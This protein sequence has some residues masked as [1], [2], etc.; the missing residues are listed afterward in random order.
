MHNQN[1][2]IFHDASGRRWSR[3]KSF[4]FI[5]SIIFSLLT[6]IFIKSLFV[7][8]VFNIPVQIKE[9]KTKLKAMDQNA[10]NHYLS[11][12]EW[13]QFSRTLNKNQN[14]LIHEQKNSDFIN[15]GFYINWD[16]RS[17]KSLEENAKFLTHVASD[18]FTI[19][20][21]DSRLKINND[22]ELLH[23][24]KEKKVNFMPVL[25]NLE[26]DKWMP[27]AVEDIVNND[28]TVKEQFIKK[29]T[30]EIN[31]INAAGLIVDF[32]M[33][34][35]SYRNNY[36][37]FFELLSHQ[38]KE[39]QKQ[40]WL[41]LPMGLELRAYNLEG[42]SVF[43]DKFIASL[44]DENSEND[45]PG[46]ISSISWV[47]GWSDTI[48]AYGSPEQWI[49]DI[50][51]YGY[52]WEKNKKGGLIS[53]PDAMIRARQSGITNFAMN[54]ESLEPNFIYEIN[55]NIHEVWFLDA[56]TFLNTFNAVK[57]KMKGGVS[58]STLGF[59]DAAVWKIF[60]NFL[61]EE[62]YTD[63]ELFNQIANIQTND[64]IA[65]VGEG[66]L[67]SFDNKAFDGKR[68][69][70]QNTDGSFYETYT[71]I[72]SYY[73]VSRQRTDSSKIAI[74]FDDGPDP[75]YT[76]KLL[77][78]LKENNVQATFF[79]L[80]AKAEKQ[81]EL[82][83]RI[84]NEGHL[85]GI[86]SYTH[87]D[88]Y[89]ISRERITLELNASERLIQAITGKSALLFRPP[90]S[91]NKPISY[92]EFN[93][94][95]QIQDMGY[96]TIAYTI[97][98]KDWEKPGVEKILENI[99]NERNEGNVVLLHDAGGDRSQT[100]EALPLII[101]FFRDRG[102]KIVSLDEVAG[103][104]KSVLMPFADAGKQNLTRIVAGTGIKVKRWLNEIFWAFIIISTVLVV[105]RGAIVFFF[106]LRYKTKK[107]QS[108]DNLF[109]PQVTILISAYNEG[110]VIEKTLLSLIN[111]DYKGK[112]EIIIIDD[113]SKDDTSIVVSSLAKKFPEIIL[114]RQENAGKA[115]ALK[116][117]ISIAKNEIIIM[118]DADTQFQ[119]DT[120]R[121]LVIPFI[122]PKVGA[123]SGHA[124][125]GNSR[126]FI[127]RC[128]DLEYIS[129]FNLDRRAYHELN[130]I[131]VVPGA[132]CAV[133]K[134]ALLKAGGITN[135]TL[136]EDTDFT[137]SLH[138]TGYRVVY[139]K[140][141][142]AWTEAPETIKSL[143]K[144]RIRWGYGT[145]QCLWK[146]RDMA[147]SPGFGTLGL[148]AIPGMW[149]FHI[150]LIAIGPVIDTFFLLTLLNPIN[151]VLYIFFALFILIDIF[152][153]I[154]ACIMEGE[155]IKKSFIIIPMRFFYK[156]LL[157]YVMWKVLLRAI[158][159]IWV[160]WGKLD[161]SASVSINLDNSLI[162]S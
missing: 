152:L 63:E 120:V 115:L 124:R 78:I 46:P 40:L 153:A 48:S 60:S 116:N 112:K 16:R 91:D 156:A 45:E 161:R 126:N 138:R 55:N 38:L 50:G 141:A 98:S 145:L 102:D 105:L 5:F 114:V 66:E 131:T 108:K 33:I 123:V 109:N 122:D 137:L 1:S 70:I 39:N 143:V 134:T 65:N 14:N 113:G 104:D 142:V 80:G 49:I 93:P 84:V 3:F 111:S 53:F 22:E 162:K 10:D 89:Q 128:Q 58:I 12:K 133:R 36:T 68:K 23:L 52:D 72:P 155:G 86:H 97:D 79:I 135:D 144:Q 56:V 9:M 67:L 77:D 158:Q 127:S 146:H 85:I 119:K 19:S 147:F 7:K 69:I 6:V 61:E 8:P 87:P 74:T 160:G 73:N 150:F 121:N 103:I 99:K 83:R 107:Y 13:L 28:N 157:G 130:C 31:E 54:K 139:A 88:I 4:F 41:C 15:L 30:E 140:N 32:G 47:Q 57:T 101:K 94:F 11:K 118:L 34:D 154:A 159:G 29:I 106:A 42:L 81:P 59:E 125:V 35:P 96:F 24:L 110:K 75:Q 82:V 18:W 149:F 62:P 26:T 25:K 148:F 136:A 64:I 21:D 92:Q 90:Y 20:L 2:F 44:H 71:E 76:P 43:V 17:W 37:Q 129:G 100:V 51:N 95:I 27:E 151:P 132:V 117:G